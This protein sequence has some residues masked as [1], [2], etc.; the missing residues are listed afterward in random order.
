[1]VGIIE[2]LVVVRIDH[3]DVVVVVV[4]VVVDVDVDVC[5]A[6]WLL[7]YCMIIITGG[8][9]CCMLHVAYCIVM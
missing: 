1:M 7:Q 5:S 4:V 9:A 6:L 8:V 3:I 2:K